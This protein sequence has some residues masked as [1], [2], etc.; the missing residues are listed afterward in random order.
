MCPNHTHT[1]T[2]REKEVRIEGDRRCRA[3]GSEA[4]RVVV[5]KL[6]RERERGGGGY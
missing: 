2:Q 6:G 3:G 1:L 5:A 4:V